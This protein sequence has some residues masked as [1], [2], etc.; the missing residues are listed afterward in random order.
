MQSLQH[1]GVV[2]ENNLD[3]KCL[4]VYLQIP[5]KETHSLVVYTDSLPD[6]WHQPI[7][8]LLEGPE[9]QTAKSLS[10]VFHRRILPVTNKNILESLHVAGLLVSVPVEFVYLM[11]RPNVKMPLTDIL[12][13]MGTLSDSTKVSDQNANFY[14]DQT[15][16]GNDEQRVSSANSLLVQASLLEEDARSHR[17]RA[18]KI[19]PELRPN[20]AQKIVE[21]VRTTGKDALDNL[22]V[23]AGI[24]NQTGES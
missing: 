15:I 19:A 13:A 16:I 24:Q 22:D 3:K 7:M 11:P 2:N 21:A 1:I 10:E 8:N 17:E 9:A 12:K 6:S 4:V 20:T 23:N 5:N 14:R 18:Y